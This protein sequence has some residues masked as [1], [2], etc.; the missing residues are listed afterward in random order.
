MNEEVCVVIPIYKEILDMQEE[1]VLNECRDK[2][3]GLDFFFMAPSDLNISYYK[4]VEHCEI[5]SFSDWR[6]DDIL[7]YNHLL[8]TSDFYKKFSAYEYMFIFQLD[9]M[10]LKGLDELIHF[11]RM[12]Y[13]YMGAPWPGEGYRYCKRL[14]PGS[15]HISSLRRFQ[16]ET[17]CKV[18]NGGVS[19]RKVDS[20]I[21]FFDTWKFEAMTWD[22]AE[23]IFISF[24]GQKRKYRLNIA[25]VGIAKQFSL[26]IDMKEKIGNGQIPFAV[27]KWEKYYPELLEEIGISKK[28]EKERK[29]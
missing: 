1:T 28:W 14:I 4:K 27:H 18:G 2:L 21:H 16:G 23:D 26:E 5:L 19:I 9:G 15:G 8:M 24:Y 7:D 22:K 20:M 10:L 3:E 13:D 25:P 12:G 6:K 17:I 29:V 11:I